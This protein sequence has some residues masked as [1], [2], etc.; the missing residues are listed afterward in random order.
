[1]AQL[2]FVTIPY[3]LCSNCFSSDAIKFLW[4]KFPFDGSK[5][6]AHVTVTMNAVGNCPSIP[7]KHKIMTE[8]E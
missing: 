8:H 4:L 5:F 1:M 6:P 7:E 3:Q 2:P